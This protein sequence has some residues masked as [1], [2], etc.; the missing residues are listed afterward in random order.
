MQAQYAFIF[1][2]PGVVPTSLQISPAERSDSE[3]FYLSYVAKSG[4][5]S[6]EAREREYPRYRELCESE[7]L[8]IAPLAST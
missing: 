7:W 3:L 6:E 8:C 4:A 1:Y 2:N 5:N